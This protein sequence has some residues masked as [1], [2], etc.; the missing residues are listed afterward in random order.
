M[1][2]L[3]SVATRDGITT[4]A[5]GL[6]SLEVELFATDGTRE[7]LAQDGVEVK[8][9]TELTGVPAM[10]NGQVKTFHHAVYAG[11][12]ARRDQADQLEELK[13]EGIEPIDLVVVNVR[14]FG[15]EIGRA[16]VG[17]DGTPVSSVTG[18]TSTPSWA[19]C[20]RVPSVAKSSTS[21]DCR[22]RANVVIPSRVATESSARN[23][24]SPPRRASS[25]RWLSGASPRCSEAQAWL[26]C[27]SAPSR[28]CFRRG[29]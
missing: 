29:V 12:L 5:R 6:Q 25:D 7:H 21:S 4:F 3:L 11:I 17:I 8:P 22:P 16:L 2:A 13:R 9:V 14:P 26:P 28:G 20:S 18:L 27:P 15:A 1:R 19:R 24:Q 10:L 23:P